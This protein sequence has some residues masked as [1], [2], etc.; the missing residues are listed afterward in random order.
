MAAREIWVFSED[1]ALRAELMAGARMLAG[2]EDADVVA[3]ILG[4]R[5]LAEEAIREGADRALVFGKTWEDGML[6]DCVPGFAGLVEAH[7]PIIVIV[8]ATTRGRLFSGRLAA[9]IRKTVMTDALQVDCVEGYLEVLHIVFGGGAIRLERPVGEPIIL[10]MG[11]GIFEPLPYDANRTGLIE[12]SI[13][14]EPERRIRLLER[15]VRPPATV[16]LAEARKVVCP[17]RGIGKQED[18]GM[19]R[20]LSGL[21]GAEVGCTRPLT[22]GVDWLPRERYIGISGAIIKPD[23]YMGIGVSGQVQHTVGITG[24]RVVVAI[25]RDPNAPLFSVADYGLVG[26][27]YTIVPLLIQ[28]LK[29]RK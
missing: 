19:I 9:R 3:L 12:E 29:A 28:A 15:K 6:E 24:S 26:D 4:Q 18:L 13:C 27:L 1:P 7:Q 11:P 20:E 17:G 8:G 2:K 22:E 25:N 5:S 23:L 16:N 14:D 21:L 10:T